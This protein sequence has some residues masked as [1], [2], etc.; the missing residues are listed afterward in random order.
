[1]EDFE[2]EARLAL[3]AQRRAIIAEQQNKR[4]NEMIQERID[5][6]DALEN[7]RI[8]RQRLREEKRQINQTI[9]MDVRILRKE[10]FVILI[11]NTFHR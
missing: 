10:N 6:L 9:R 5:R 1:M 2:R 8:E 3:M 7:Q 4:R 11:K